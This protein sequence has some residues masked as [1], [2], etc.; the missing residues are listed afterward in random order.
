V[1]GYLFSEP[2]P[3]QEVQAMLQRFKPVAKAVA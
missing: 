3:A 1:Q 2:K